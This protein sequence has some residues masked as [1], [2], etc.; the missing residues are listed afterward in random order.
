MK[1][2]LLYSIVFILA[3]VA[4]A[5]LFALFTDISDKK[6][7]ERHYPLMLAK[8]DELKPDIRE[9]GKNF[10]SQ[11]DAT[12]AMKDITF[13][14]PFAG[15]LPYSKLIR[16]PAASVFWQGYAFAVD[17][18]RPRLH[19]YTQIDQIETKRNDKEYLNAHGLPNFKGQPGFCV[20]CHTGHLTAIMNDPDYTQ[21]HDKSTRTKSFDLEM[22][23]FAADKEK[24]EF[25]K[26]AW[27]KMN[28]IPYFDV[29]K[30]VESKHGKDAFGGSHLG[31]ACADCHHPEDMSLRVTRPGFVNAMVKRGYE[32]DARQGIKATRAQMRD[33]VC[34]QCHVEYYPGL[35]ADLVFPWTKW[36][37][38]EP[39]KI[40]MF[41][42]YYDEVHDN[43]KFAA[44]YRHKQTDAKMIKMQHPEAE[45]HSTSVHARSGVTCVDCHMP[46]KRE[47]ATKITNHTIQTPYADITAACKTCHMQSEDELKDRISFIQ[48]R[49][50][51]ELRNCENNLL[52]L[53][54]DINVARAEL[55]KHEKFAS[56]ADE[57][58]RK[59]AI[60]EALKEP[61][62]AH[63]KAH[64]R[65]DFAFSEN[66]Y[67]FH[68]PQEVARITGQCQT[69][70]REGQNS[71]VN[72][73]APYGI[74]IALTKEAKM[75]PAPE[76][77]TS[78]HAPVAT[79]PSDRL[80]KI[81]EDV[82]NLNFK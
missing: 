67:G 17:Y 35:D 18:N 59:E 71:L 16:W 58:A 29:M 26:E 74:T 69:V 19:F 9:W 22:G 78:H 8:N 70:A 65:W 68:G 62:Y 57:K 60:S 40:E 47:G 36:T 33:Y 38:D 82:K 15:S 6:H 4:G 50:A 81:D 77:I 3:V 28:S 46:Y 34:M 76:Q 72:A 13:E 12:V 55:A 1:N 80:K 31:S 30:M 20:N 5:G 21:L 53:I 45:L 2:K 75:P 56:I 73:L 37:K 79:P 54:Q 32:A 10:P 24:G 27:T 23:F 14:T 48:N 51:Y 39:F 49:H 41:D 61:L 52:A 64:I 7:Q 66:S 25:K 42:E 44:D 11:Y 63:R 43:G